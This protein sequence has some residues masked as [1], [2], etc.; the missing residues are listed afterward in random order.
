MSS[1]A[2][3]LPTTGSATTI[4]GSASI[5][6]R[7]APFALPNMAVWLTTPGIVATSMWPAIN[8]TLV[9]SLSAQKYHLLSLAQP[10]RVLTRDAMFAR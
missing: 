5:A 10:R 6:V 1:A 7:L 9:S 4:Q 3:I 2:K 8:T